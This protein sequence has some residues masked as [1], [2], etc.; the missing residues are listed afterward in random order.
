MVI[1]ELESEAKIRARSLVSGAAWLPT[2][3]SLISG[4]RFLIA[5]A[6]YIKSKEHSLLSSWLVGESVVQGN[7]IRSHYWEAALTTPMIPSLE[8]EHSECTGAQDLT[9]VR[10]RSNLDHKLSSSSCT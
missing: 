2:P 6:S 5:V 10:T 8:V 9:T 3:P 7:G 4:Q 1:S